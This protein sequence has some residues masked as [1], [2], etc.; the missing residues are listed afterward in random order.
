[1]KKNIKLILLL[2]VIFTSCKS[3][4]ILI[5]SEKHATLNNFKKVYQTN[6]DSE[7]F[8]NTDNDSLKLIYKGKKVIKSEIYMQDT[9]M[10]SVFTYYQRRIQKTPVSSFMD[11]TLFKPFDVCKKKYSRILKVERYFNDT[12]I[13]AIFFYKDNKSIKK[14]E[15]YSKGKLHGVSYSFYK[16]SNDTQQV[17]A[18]LNYSNGVFNGLTYFFY[19]NGML[20]QTNLYKSDSILYIK[21]HNKKGEVTGVLE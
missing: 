2:F 11:S 8:I 10:L 15:N 6:D 7:I 20:K 3:G 5:P 17:K 1:M 4:R 14:V 13:Q 19:K 12:I 18:M 9:P 16:S 21:L